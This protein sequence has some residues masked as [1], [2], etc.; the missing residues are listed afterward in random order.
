MGY[1]GLPR[2][3]VVQPAIDLELKQYTLLAY[4]QRIRKRFA[5]KKLYPYLEDVRSHLDELLLLRGKKDM[6]SRDLARELKG[7]DPVTG[8]AIH[9]RPMEDDLLGVVD[10][11][12]DLAVPDLERIMNEGIGLRSDIAGIIRFEPIG[13]QP[14]LANEGWLFLRTGR[15]ARVYG[16]ALNILRELDEQ[17]QYRSIVTRYVSTYPLTLTNTFEHIRSDLICRFRDL[18]TPAVFLFETDLGIP[19]IETFMPLAKQRVYEYLV[20]RA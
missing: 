17:H 14:I 8:H 19:H 6:L 3:W 5:E 1:Y 13:V 15:E 10:A 9:E 4:L 18:P 7:F 2:N 16:Y 12:I 11:V 20:G